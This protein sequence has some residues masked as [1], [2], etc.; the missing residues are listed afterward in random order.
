MEDNLFS[1]SCSKCSNS[2]FSAFFCNP[3]FFFKANC[4]YCG[5]LTRLAIIP[6]L[7]IVVGTLL[8]ATSIYSLVNELELA[9]MNIEICALGISLGCYIFGIIFLRFVQV[10]KKHNC[11][12]KV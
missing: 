3:M 10:Q 5:T 12:K 9:S 7:L 11:Y 2:L 8:G 4:P 6:T 1:F